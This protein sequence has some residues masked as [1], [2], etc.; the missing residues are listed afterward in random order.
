LPVTTLFRSLCT[1]TCAYAKEVPI[2]C[3]G[4][5][6]SFFYFFISSICPDNSLE[7]FLYHDARACKKGSKS[8]RR[9]SFFLFLELLLLLELSCLGTS[10]ENSL[11]QDSRTWKRGPTSQF[12]GN[13]QN[14][15]IFSF[16]SLVLTNLLRILC[17]ITRAHT[18]E[19]QVCQG[20]LC[21]ESSVSESCVSLVCLLCVSG[22]S[23]WHTW[24]S[25]G[26]KYNI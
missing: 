25:L 7:K 12:V 20:L 4:P 11:H 15:M 24:T 18:R 23:P 8:I 10:L 14:Y 21:Q 22:K 19:V 13:L 16:N 2:Q 26:C 17:T 3:A 1:V 5:L 9:T 6:E